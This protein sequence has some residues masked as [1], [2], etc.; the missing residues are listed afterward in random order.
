M[1]RYI[2]LLTLTNEGKEFVPCYEHNAAM[3][4][5]AQAP[6]AARHCASEAAIDEKPV[7]W[8]SGRY[9]RVSCLGKAAFNAPNGII[10]RENNAS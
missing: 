1:N 4:I 10:C 2:Y 5:V 3:V 8:L 7:T 6:S 9:S